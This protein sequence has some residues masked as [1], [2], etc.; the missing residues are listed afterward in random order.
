MGDVALHRVAL[1]VLDDGRVHGAV[2]GEV[3]DGVGAGGAGQGEAQVAAA[4]G[5][6]QRR[7]AVAVQHGGDHVVVAHAAGGGAARRAAGVGDEH[8]GSHGSETFANRRAGSRKG[9]RTMLPAGR[10]RRHRAE[11]ACPGPYVRGDDRPPRPHRRPAPAAARRL[12][13]PPS[14]R[15]RRRGARRRRRLQLGPLLPA[16]RRSPTASTSSAG[17]CSPRGPSRPTASR[18]APSSRA[19]ATATRSC[20]PTWPAPSTTSAA[21]G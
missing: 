10:G 16:L 12:R 5:D 4:D 11:S 2:D 1:Q 15:R 17:R 6:G 14:R 3:E 7:H 18:S 8:G 9:Q 20:S 19:T 21:G 13:R